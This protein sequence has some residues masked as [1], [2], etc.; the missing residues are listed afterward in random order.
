M[1]CNVLLAGTIPTPT[2]PTAAMHMRVPLLSSERDTADLRKGS[3]SKADASSLLPFH[4]A[5]GKIIMQRF[6]ESWKDSVMLTL[7]GILYYV[8]QHFFRLLAID[9]LLFVFQRDI[10]RLVAW[11]TGTAD[12]SCTCKYG[13]SDPSR[14]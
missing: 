3:S 1:C 12:I 9:H 7:Q 10:Q 4:A 5:D 11:V 2:L 13:N 8:L 14:F 6:V